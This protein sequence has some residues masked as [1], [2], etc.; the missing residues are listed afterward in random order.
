MF[1]RSVFGATDSR[2]PATR[3]Q[4][5]FSSQLLGTWC[6]AAP[7]LQNKYLAPD[8]LIALDLNPVKV[9]AIRHTTI[10]IVSPIPDFV[11][12]GRARPYR[13]LDQRLDRL[14]SEVENP[15]GDAS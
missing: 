5:A 2:T 6:I 15:Y 4:S 13:I 7:L 12:L 14:H 9:H 11:V 3:E 10:R 1:C 8:R